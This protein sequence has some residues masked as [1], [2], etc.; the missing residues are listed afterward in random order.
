[1]SAEGKEKALGPKHPDKLVSVSNL[2]I[3]TVV[4]GQVRGGG[5]DEHWI[6]RRRRWVIEDIA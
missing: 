6:G 4:L 1:M 2:A 5:G 3:G